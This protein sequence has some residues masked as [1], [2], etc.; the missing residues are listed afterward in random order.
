MKAAALAMLAAGCAATATP[1]P[2][3]TACGPRADVLAALES[4]YGE[5]ST[6]FGLADGDVVIE[7]TVSPAG[8][9]T[10]LA[11]GPDGLSC[12]ILA[13]EGWMEAPKGTKA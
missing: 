11:T 7:I 10:M 9:W 4:Q 8:T 6:A 3:P 2:V 12:V 13:G 1:P 5:R